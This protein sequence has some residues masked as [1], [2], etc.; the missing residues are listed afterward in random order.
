MN[1]EPLLLARPSGEE[2]KLCPEGP[3]IAANVSLLETLSRSVGADVDRSRAVTLDMS[4]VSALDTLGAWVLEKLSRRASSSGQAAEFIGVADHFSGLMDE[5]RQVNRHT[6]LPAPAPNPIVLRLNDLGKS[7]VGA[8]EDITI[9]LQM[10]GAL[11]IAVIGVL[12]RP[13]S[14]RLTSLIY[15]LYRIGWQAIPIVVLITFLIGAIIAQQGFFHFRRF[16][17]ESYT[18]D[19][20]GILVLRELGVLIVAIMVAGRSG[21]A[22]TAELGSM[23]MREEIDAL[24]T[25]G[26]DPV[27]VLILPRVAALVIALPILAFIGSIAALYGGGLVAQFYGGMA[28]AIYIARL[29]E[30]ISVTHFEVGILKAPF[31]ALV[32]GVVACSEGLRVKGSAESLGRQTTTS[33]VKSIFLVIVLDGL[34]AIFFA[35]IGM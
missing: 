5:V 2:L 20:V 14:L 10:L 18:V 11:F 24:S 16:G 29:H 25:M 33:V 6:P 19:M 1:S 7:T 12:R 17:A 35:S 13:R 32:I 9:F 8:R 4:G 31:M 15:Q 27:H 23:K 22:Y 30:A 3:W 28:P 21:S 34:F 26:L